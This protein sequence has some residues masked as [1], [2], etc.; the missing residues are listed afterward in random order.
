EGRSPAMIKR[1][2]VSLG[3]IL[4]DAMERGL[5]ARNV[6][7]EMAQRRGKSRASAVEK[8]QK[9]RLR[10]GVDIPTPVEVGRII[11]AAT[12][13]YRPLLLTAIFGGLRASELRG[14]RWD[15]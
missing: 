1:V 2:S 7:R 10:V 4:A 6:V 9:A 5:V 13:R 14:L 15:D 3:S 11:Q 12:G 8:R